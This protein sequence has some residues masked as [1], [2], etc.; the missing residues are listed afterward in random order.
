L[1]L[2]FN[3]RTM[4]KIHKFEK[5]ALILSALAF[6]LVVA[7]IYTGYPEFKK[8]LDA[9]AR[10]KDVLETQGITR[11]AEK[12]GETPVTPAPAIK[13][14]ALLDMPY[15]A[16]A[17]FANWAVHEESCEEAAALMYHYFLEGQI[18]FGGSTIIPLQKAND[19]MLAMKS[20]QVIKYSKEPDLTIEAWGKYMQQYY[21][22]NYKT[23]KNVTVDDIKREVSAGNPVVVPVIT[24]AL[25]NPHYGRQPSYHLL[26]IKGYKPEGVITNDA[27]VKEGENYF[28]TWDILFS[29]IDAQTP[30]MGQGREMV[31]IMK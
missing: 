23:F 18:I 25:Q 20:W 29:A 22:Y 17:P 21:G 8:Y 10:N 5:K 16:Q 28:Y 26:V 24:H 3:L 13:P 31:V 1:H 2:L 15:T 19:E 7:G 14:S 9:R 12:P 30:K 6:F 11:L 4:K 27:G